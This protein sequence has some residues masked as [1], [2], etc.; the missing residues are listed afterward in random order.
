MNDSMQMDLSVLYVEDDDTTREEMKLFLARRVRKVVVAAN[1]Q[2]GL[3]LFH[4]NTIDLVMTDIRMPIMDGLTMAE[5]MRNKQPTLQIIVTTAYSDMQ[6][7]IKAIDIGVDQYVLKP[8]DTSKLQVALV[9]CASVIHAERERKHHQAERERLI[10]DLQKALVE[11]RKLQGIL[12]ICS[13]CKKIRDDKG[14]WNQIETYIRD[15]SEAD[16]SHSICPECAEQLYPGFY[17]KN[18]E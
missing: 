1:G 12:P 8:I 14:S 3:N 13:S 2:D 11:I 10:A 17:R 6:N 7:L 18:A 4:A 9:K 16:F 5:V 15:H